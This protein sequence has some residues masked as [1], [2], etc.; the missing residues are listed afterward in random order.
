MSYLSPAETAEKL[1]I[2]YRSLLRLVKNGA[3]TGAIKVLGS[4]QI[5]LKSVEDYKA[6]LNMPDE[7]LT[8]AE[9][10]ERLNLSELW[11]GRLIREEH[12]LGQRNIEVLG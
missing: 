2:G 8:I 7:Y 11:V 4:W 1:G 10:A 5:P 12:L 9:I 6:L 3:F